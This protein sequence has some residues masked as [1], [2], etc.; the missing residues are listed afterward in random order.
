MLPTLSS[1]LCA[2]AIFASGAIA[3]SGGAQAGLRY[4]ENWVVVEQDSDVIAEAFPEVNITLRSPAFLEPEAVPSRF[5][6]GSEGPTDDIELG[7]FTILQLSCIH[8]S[9]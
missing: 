4:G 3:Q 9:N 7:E 1:S 6:N 8:V 2:G 5:A